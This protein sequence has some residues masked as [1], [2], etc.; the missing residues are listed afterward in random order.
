M[1]IQHDAYWKLIGVLGRIGAERG[2]LAEQILDL[3]GTEVGNFCR[4]FDGFDHRVLQDM[5]DYIAGYF[6]FRNHR[7][8]LFAEDADPSS[9]WFAWQDFA[10]REFKRL[11]DIPEFAV[12]FFDAIRF[13]NKERG[14]A[15]EKAMRSVQIECYREMLEERKPESDP[16]GSGFGNLADKL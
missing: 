12:G 9:V 16:E 2:M 8:P 3:S 14:T 13:E 1:K 6:R 15:G 5:H 7:W 4:Q 11:M 10:I